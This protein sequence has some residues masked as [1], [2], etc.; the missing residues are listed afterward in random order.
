MLV[1]FYRLIL[2][3]NL[4]QKCY[5]ILHRHCSAFC[6]KKINM[7]NMKKNNKEDKAISQDIK[8]E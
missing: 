2:Q 3:G 1:F 7:Q 8:S 4:I 5:T 6:E